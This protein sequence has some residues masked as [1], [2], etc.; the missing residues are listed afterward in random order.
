LK[1][2]KKLLPFAQPETQK[3]L[4]A[5]EIYHLWEALTSGY[6]LVSVMETYQ[7]N[8][9][10]KELHTLLQ[11]L[12]KGTYLIRINRLEKVLKEEGFTVP[13]QPSSKT[14]QGKPG[15][16]QEVKLNDEEVI[17]NIIAWVQISLFQNSKAVGAC[18]RESVRKIFTDLLF[19]EMKAFDLLMALGS[20]RQAYNTPPPATARDNSLNMGEVFVLWEELGARHLSVVNA[21]TYLANTNDQV[22]IK[23]IQQSIYEVVLPQLEQLEN[24]LK[25][26]G[27]TV[28]SRPVRRMKQ[29]PPGQV[30]KITLSDDEIIGV[31]TTAAQVAIAHHVRAYCVAVRDDIRKLFKNF[32]STEIEEYQKLMQLASERNTLDNPPVV[33]SRRG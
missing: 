2:F 30:N 9:E 15:V 27:F 5:G 6:K 32:T 18:T 11:G 8:T 19:D 29:G 13:P 23:L 25:A 1:I 20:S 7:M 17:R 31:L 3:P 24:T 4:H 16:G 14:L 28:P 10:D 12:V 21:E 26:E 33:T 22:L